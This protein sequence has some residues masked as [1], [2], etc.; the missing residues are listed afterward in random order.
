MYH[1]F[2]LDL[3]ADPISDE[4]GGRAGGRNWAVA[5]FVAGAR[6]WVKFCSG[7]WAVLQ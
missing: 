2:G 1:Y 5:G 3:P 6:D 7:K 4:V